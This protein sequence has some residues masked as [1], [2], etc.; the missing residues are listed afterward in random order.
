[1]GCA[2][3]NHRFSSTGSQIKIGMGLRNFE[4]LLDTT[5]SGGSYRNNTFC[6]EE[7]L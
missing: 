5:L 7:A 2:F 1:M 4:H 6:K 3:E